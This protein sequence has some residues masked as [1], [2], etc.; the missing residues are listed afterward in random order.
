MKKVWLLPILFAL[1]TAG[2][3]KLSAQSSSALPVTM[4]VD[5]VLASNN[6]VAVSWTI[7]IKLGTDYFDVEKSQDG[8]SWHS[9]AVVK[10][11]TSAAVPF[12]YTSFDLFP[13]RGANFYRIRV[14]DLTGRTS[15]TPVKT[16]RVAAFCNMAIYPNPASGQVNISLGQVP[17]NDWHVSL[18]TLTGQVILQKKCNR[19]S[20]VTCLSVNNIPAGNYILEITD[21]NIKQQK[22]LLINHS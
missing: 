5:A 6:K 21:G 17:V 11:D 18:I 7:L 14:K 20:I 10:P 2:Y 15:F 22:R 13:V 19:T 9:I 12:T 3:T 4:A 1:T 16:V 8:I